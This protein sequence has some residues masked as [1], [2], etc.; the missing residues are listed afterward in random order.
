MARYKV[1]KKPYYRTKKYYKKRYQKKGKLGI[2]KILR[3]NYLFVK[4]M[5]EQHIDIAGTY[6]T[7][8]QVAAGNAQ[9][10][11]FIR[12]VYDTTTYP[13]HVSAFCRIFEQVRINGFVV[14]V[15]PLA[16]DR[17]ADAAAGTPAIPELFMATKKILPGGVLIPPGNTLRDDG[18][19]M[20]LVNR[21]VTHK[22]Y[23]PMLLN[24]IESIASPWMSCQDIATGASH[25]H[26][27]VQW[28]LNIQNNTVADLNLN[29]YMILYLEFRNAGLN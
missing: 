8:L 3:N 25:P 9:S 26:N 5:T 28:Q 16:T 6:D 12:A 18:V 13:T 10:Q 4:A 14:Q 17:P 20:K 27:G 23:K 22:V 24:N 29:V 2:G 15:R 7:R 21:T 11:G 1:F 19:K